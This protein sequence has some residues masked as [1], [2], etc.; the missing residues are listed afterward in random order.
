MN[1]NLML[2]KLNKS[3]FYIDDKG[4]IVLESEDL[5][6]EINGSSGMFGYVGTNGACVN[7]SC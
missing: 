5:M 3:E 6:R 2:E 1:T 4:R 7:G